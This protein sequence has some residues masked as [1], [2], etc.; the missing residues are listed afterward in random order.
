MGSGARPEQNDREE[1]SLRYR[2][3]GNS[4]LTVSEIAFGSRL[5]TSGGVARD[6][7]IACVHRAL[8]RGVTLIDTANVYGR[9]I[10]EQVIGEALVGV[11]RDSYVLATKVYFPMSD[12]DRGLSRA[13]IAK[14]LDASLRRFKVHHV[15]LYQCHRYIT[16]RLSR[17]PCGP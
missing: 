3:L 4:D 5:T 2:K 17:K 7:A 8:D 1:T 13:Q 10:A 9:G 16:R 12:S 15:D 14:Q 11:S 6:Q